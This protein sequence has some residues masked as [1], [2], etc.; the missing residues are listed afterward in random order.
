MSGDLLRTKLY[1]PRQ[2]PSL[3]PRPHLIAALDHG[4]RHGCKLTLISAPAGFGKTTLVTA[5]VTASERP[6]AWLSLDER[7]ADLNRFLTYFITALQSLGQSGAAAGAAAVGEGVLTVLQSPQ[8][9]STESLL[10]SLLNDIAVIREDFLL[11]LDDYHLV[12][13]HQVDGALTFLLSHL[14]PQMHLVISTREDPQVPLARL[15][16][17][18]L[19][20]E[21]RADDLRFSATET[22]IFLRQVMGLD[23]A[24]ENIVALEARTEGWIAGLQL[25]A[26]S[27]RGHRDDAAAFI[28]AFTGSH[29]FVLDY[30]VEEVLAQQSER[31]QKFLLETAVL[32]QLSGPLCDAL[33]GADDGQET[34]AALERANLFLVP[35]DSERRWFRYHHLFAEL[36]RQRL[37]Q[38]ATDREVAE[39]HIRASEWYEASGLE[40]EAFQHAAAAND[41]ERAARLIAGEDMPLHFRGVVAPVFSWLDGLDAAVLD[42]HP[43]LW[44]TY[45]ST[46]SIA[47]QNSR[48]EPVLQA[49]EA[50]LEATEPDAATRD[51][52][53]HI[54]AIRAML[55]APQYQPEIVIAQSRRALEYLHP[56]NLPVRTSA[57]WTL[58]Y[59]YHLQG[60]RG[61][62]AQAYRDTI[63]ISEATGNVFVNILASTSLGVLQEADNQLYRAAETYRRVRELAGEP[64]SPMACE[65]F[66]GLARV[67][68]EWND[69]DAA[70]QFGE[71]SLQLAGQ[72]ENIDGTAAAALFLARLQLAGGDVTGAREFLTRASTFAHRHQFSEQ[73]A[74]VMALQVRLFLHEGNLAAAARLAPDVS[75][76]DQARVH[77]A[78]GNPAAALTVLEAW[79][80]QAETS[81]WNDQRLRALVLQALAYQANG[82]MD[83]A[84][85]LLAE[86]LAMAEPNGFVRLFVDEGPAM[87]QLLAAAVAQGM[88]AGYAGVLLPAFDDLENGRVG[89]VHAAVSQPL[90][91]T[92]TER[93]QEVL[94]LVAQGLSNRE[95]SERLFLALSTV[96]GHNRNIYSKLGVQRRTEAVARARELGLL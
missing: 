48:V 21:L 74:A 8:P 89:R 77:L 31:V 75:S 76:A 26:V 81:G 52:T 79:R 15:R 78:Q 49:A 17:R 68:Y 84:L 25:A 95:I 42:A 28:E 14:P 37:R 3:V 12:D 61:A 9:P 86:A 80:H 56:N 33:T 29:R 22:A 1:M 55:A 90:V 69:L 72:I 58:G 85:I 46:L 2:R 54:A 35:L 44:V 36:L 65:A 23:L 63:A 18:G 34:L 70:L 40:V 88:V 5:W 4:L 57:S 96:K 91:E 66:L 38:S 47:G 92:L 16:A 32:D 39:L 41:V 11:V 53:G 10:T 87:A 6:F 13:S 73:I 83:R 45:A 19:L 51:L 43:A 27:M 59:G 71:Q 50:A 7:D 94:Q 30:L 60:D 82:V 20:S 64:P 67:A 93:E 24:E 62:A